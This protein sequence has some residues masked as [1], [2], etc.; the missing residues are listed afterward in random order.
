MAYEI[1]FAKSAQKELDKLPNPFGLKILNKIEALA[2]NPRPNGCKNLKE[3]R[4]AIEFA[5]II[6][7]LFIQFMTVN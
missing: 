2:N 3:A 7:A 5:S 1:V 6:I 4:I